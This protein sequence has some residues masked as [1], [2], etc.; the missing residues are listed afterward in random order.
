MREAIIVMREAIIKMR[1]YRGGGAR[2]NEGGNHLNEGGN[3]LN[4]AVPQRRSSSAKAA[5]APRPVRAARSTQRHRSGEVQL[6][7]PARSRLEPRL[8][9]GRSL[10]G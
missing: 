10:G 6:A 5:A 8:E 7:A 4:E 9:T 1:Q 3:H 2:L